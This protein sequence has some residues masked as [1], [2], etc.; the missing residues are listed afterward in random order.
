MLDLLV[1]F[2]L[3]MLCN[4]MSSHCI[5]PCCDAC[6]YSSVKMMFDVLKEKRVIIY[7]RP[8]YLYMHIGVQREFHI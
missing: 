1:V 4:Y 3:F 7:L 5:G 2:L 6:Y 8:Q